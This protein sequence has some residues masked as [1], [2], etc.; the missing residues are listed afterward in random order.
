[1]RVW[2]ISDTHFFHEKIKFY[3]DRPDNW[4]E[5]IIDNWND[6]ISEEDNVWHLGDFM[7]GKQ[8]SKIKY[9]KE[10][11]IGN[12]KLI[13][14]NH[15]RSGSAWFMDNF[16]MELIK[17]RFIT[18]VI[19]DKKIALSHVPLKAELLKKEKIYMNIH[20][21]IHNSAYAIKE[22]KNCLWVNV[23]VEVINYKPVSFET[24]MK[25]VEFLRL[26]KYKEME[27]MFHEQ[28]VEKV[29]EKD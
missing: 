6:I 1:M 28:H 11:L 25:N 2:F 23:S 26:N 5:K 18:I 19:E 3:C 20:G 24:I 10:N 9:L 15:E 16:N 21:H 27:I 22:E 7:F 17:K 13:Q 14:G 4:F 8:E 12:V 29:D